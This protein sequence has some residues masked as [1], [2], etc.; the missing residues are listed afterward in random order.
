LAEISPHESDVSKLSVQRWLNTFVEQPPEVLS[1]HSDDGEGLITLKIGMSSPLVRFPCRTPFG[2]VVEIFARND[3]SLY[4]SL[5]VPKT[6]MGW[7]QVLFTTCS[8]LKANLS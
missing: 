3:G 2:D 8:T 4:L 6:A 7:N 1:L 5:A